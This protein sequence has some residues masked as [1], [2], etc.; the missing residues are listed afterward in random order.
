MDKQTLQ[1][2]SYLLKE[3][4]HLE[5]EKELIWA[6]Y[7]SPK[8][9]EGLPYTSGKIADPVAEL[10]IK[11]VAIDAKIDELINIKLKIEDAIKFLSSRDRDIMRL[12]YIMEKSDEQIGEELG[13]SDRHIRRLLRKI[14]TKLCKLS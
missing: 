12:K 6:H 11:E 4:K 8:R 10:A 14:L 5:E 1:Q 9:Q 2:F 3:L 13:Y 7:L